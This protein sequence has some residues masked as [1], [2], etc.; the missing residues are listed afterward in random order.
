MKKK[1]KFTYTIMISFML[2]LLICPNEILSKSSATIE[3][4]TSIEKTTIVS[5][6]TKQEYLQSEVSIYPEII[7]YEIY[8][9]DKGMV[10][11]GDSSIDPYI[12]IAPPNNKHFDSKHS[13]LLPSEE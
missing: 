2:M 12:L 7:I 13:K 9:I 5:C 8:D 11:Q 1:M 3:E 10:F 6:L 4:G